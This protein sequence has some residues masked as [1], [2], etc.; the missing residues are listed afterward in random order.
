MRAVAVPGLVV[1]VLLTSACAGPKAPFEVGT[2]TAPINLVLG[3][4]QAV[5]AAPVGPVLGP[6]P[7]GFSPFIPELPG[8]P[9]PS[10]SPPTVPSPPSEPCPAFDP[11]AP[12]SASGIVL[13]GPP[14]PATYTYR[15]K[16][17]DTAGTSKATYQG[18][19][20]WKVTVSDAD[21]ETGGYQVTTEVSLGKATSKRVLL[22][23]PTSLTADLTD[24]PYFDPDSP[25]ATDPNAIL[26]A[27]VNSTLVMLGLPVLPRVLPNPGRYGVAGIYLVSQTSGSSTF[28]PDVPIPLLQTPVGNNSFTGMGT[29]GSTVMTFTS[30]VNKRTNVNACGTKVEGIEVSLTDGRLAGRTADGTVQQVAFEETLVFGLQFGGLPVHDAGTITTATAPGAAVAPDQASREFSFTVNSVPKPA[31]I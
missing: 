24:P 19:S 17:V 11:L 30:T 7:P 21:P 26:A 27:Q 1:A 14:Q 3:A 23:L 8:L 22:V 20:S 4:R 9:E 6:L 2:Q 10:V 15:G 12:V 13:P 16:V 28:T 18:D 29:D 31:R 5:E 25:D